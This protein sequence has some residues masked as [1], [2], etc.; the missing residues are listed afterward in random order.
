M[1]S[2]DFKEWFCSLNEMNINLKDR[3][4]LRIIVNKLIQGDMSWMVDNDIK[5]GDKGSYWIL[6]Y[7]VKNKNEF[8]RLTRGLVV[9]KP[10]GLFSGDPLLLIKSFPFIRFFN[11][12]ETHA[13]EINL[14]N[15]EM[16][17]KMDGTMVGVFFP[18]GDYTDPHW[19]TRKMLS[20][21]KPDLELTVGGFAGGNYKLMEIIGQ[22]VRLL[23]FNQED[24][25]Y[26]YV[27]EFIHTASE[28]LTKYKEE[29]YGLYLLAARNLKT[30]REQSE[31]TLDTIATR[32]KARRPGRWDFR[33]DEKEISKIMRQ[34]ASEVENFEGI[35]FRDKETGNRIKLK[36]PKY[37]EKHH[38]LDKL[39]FK[40]LIPLVFD[41]EEDEVVS[42]FPQAKKIVEEI[43][44]RHQYI[45]NKIINWIEIF[46]NQGDINRKQLWEK[47]NKSV[48][49]SFIKTCIM[50][51]INSKDIEADIEKELRNIAIATYEKDTYAG[52]QVFKGVS[53]KYLD[54]LGLR[55]EEV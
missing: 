10:D 12:G 42:Y 28:V 7:G 17:E 32:I 26:T 41:G 54:L 25:D 55:D 20:S 6:N 48:E 18:T 22:Y 51:Y 1:Q 47:V 19:H 44:N 27:F 30:H 2:L 5:V 52:K 39:S 16:L 40:R 53:K 50:K 4:G 43:K 36:D 8:N 34:I 37:V 9:K 33:A 49:E 23:N 13:D 21:H 35:V 38:L 3:D 15:S 46:R 29:Q 11:Q 14:S 31:N 45:K 24:V